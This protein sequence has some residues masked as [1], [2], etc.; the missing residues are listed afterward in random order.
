MQ[1]ERLLRIRLG[2]GVVAALVHARDGP[3]GPPRSKARRR[4]KREGA[5]RLRGHSVRQVAHVAAQP[6]LGVG[7]QRAVLLGSAQDFVDL[8][9]QGGLALAHADV[10]G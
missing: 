1:E 5:Q 4:P 2:C 7:V 8:V 3:Q 9:Q 6:L 10:V